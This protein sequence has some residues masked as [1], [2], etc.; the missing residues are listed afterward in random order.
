MNDRIWL[1]AYPKGV[2]ADIDTSDF[3]SLVALM[4]ESF[5]KYAGRTAYSFMGKDISYAQTDSLSRAFAGYL[6]S[7]GLVKGDRVAVLISGLGATPLMEQYILYASVAKY[8]GE[9]GLTVA[10]PLVGNFFT[11]LEMM[12]VTLSVLQ[13]DDELEGYMKT[14]CASIGL[15]RK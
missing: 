12:G 1:S 10:V 8:L 6:Q 4:D 9:A 3:S 11:S 13:L 5:R 7:L 2:P 15:T 14:P